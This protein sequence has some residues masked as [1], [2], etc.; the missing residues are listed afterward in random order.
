MSLPRTA[1]HLYCQNCG[2]SYALDDTASRYHFKSASISAGSYTSPAVIGALVPT[3]E[4]EYCPACD[5]GGSL[6]DSYKH[7]DQGL[8]ESPFFIGTSRMI[9][10][11][12]ADIK[13]RNAE[14][15]QARHEPDVTHDTRE[16]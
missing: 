9:G 1:T 8:N 7:L 6:A 16:G 10:E 15:D 3:E 2:T 4:I 12:E 5:V 11:E 14:L 13:A